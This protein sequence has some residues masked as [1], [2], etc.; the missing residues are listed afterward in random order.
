MVMGKSWQQE[1]KGAHYI[2]FAV[3]KQRE[4][5]IGAQLIFF[6]L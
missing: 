4:M 1:L 2:I 6:L 3:R 5:G